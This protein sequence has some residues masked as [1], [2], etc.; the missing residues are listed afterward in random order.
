MIKIKPLVT[1]PVTVTSA[2]TEIF[3]ATP[4][5]E[6]CPSTSAMASQWVVRINGIPVG[7]F[8]SRHEAAEWWR[9]VAK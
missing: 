2:V 3:H 7:Y 9:M 4:A 6:R 1:K 8:D 5:G